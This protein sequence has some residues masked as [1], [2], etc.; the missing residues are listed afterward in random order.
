MA[1]GRKENDM[2]RIISILFLTTAVVS[3]AMA[4]GGDESSV[5]AVTASAAAQ[6]P[7]QLVDALWLAENLGASDLVIL[8]TARKTVE[9]SAGHIPG[10]FYADRNDYWAEVDGLPGMF[11]G[12]DPVAAW[13][14]SLGVSNDTAVVVYDSGNGLWAAR[15][16]WTLA[17]LGHEN[18]AVLDGG[19]GLWESE[20]YELS[21]DTPVPKPGSFTADV[22]DQLLVDGNDILEDLDDPGFIV[23]DT[24][25]PGEFNGSDVRADRGGHIP[26]A[27]PIEWTLNNTDVSSPSFLSIAELSEFYSSKGVT[28]DKS[29]VTHCQTGVRG[30][31][32]WLA[33]TLA[34]YDDVALYDGSWIEWANNEDFPVE[35]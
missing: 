21:M 25:S 31:H 17:Y 19:Y 3:A 23:V 14:E 2:K 27:V 11:P 24:R 8:D 28:A 15:L 6:L 7:S 35:E 33:L 4:N 1:G 9:Y 29:I 32:T 12:V 16:A 22:Q 30:A 5:M 18:W 26:G 20:G 10:A 34:G 13:L